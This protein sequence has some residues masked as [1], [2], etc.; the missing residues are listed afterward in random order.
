M[1]TW[2]DMPGFVGS[3]KVSDHGNVR[4]VDRRITDKNGSEKYISGKALK[5]TYFSNGYAKVSVCKNGRKK[6]LILHRLIATLFIPNPQRLPEVNHKDEDKTNNRANNLEWMTHIQNIN[7]GT[8]IKRRSKTIKKNGTFSGKNNP[9]YGRVGQLHPTFG[10]RGKHHQSSIPIQRISNGR[11]D[12]QYDSLTE[13]ADDLNVSKSAIC[14]VLKGRNRR[15]KGH[16]L[17]YLTL[18]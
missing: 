14:S 15:V 18:T 1:E 17:K 11:V 5:I 4:S 12:K 9:M 7:Y 8:G 3:Y 16:E 10:I 6:Q 2:K 13:A